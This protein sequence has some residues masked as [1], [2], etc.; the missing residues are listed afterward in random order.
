MVMIEE[1]V[2]KKSRV[3]ELR[4]PK[5]RAHQNR[6]TS[7]DGARGIIFCLDGSLGGNLVYS[8]DGEDLRL[9]VGVGKKAVIYESLNNK[10]F[11]YCEGNIFRFGGNIADI[12]NSRALSRGEKKKYALFI[13]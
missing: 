1:M 2:E 3:P 13:R 7:S 8:D 12:P 9:V 10:P 6:L 11:T 5:T 4:F